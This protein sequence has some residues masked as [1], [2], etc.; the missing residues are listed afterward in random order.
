MIEKYK[1]E[2]RLWQQCFFDSEEYMDYYFENKAE[3]NK[4]LRIFKENKLVSMVHLNPYEVCWKGKVQR[5]YYIVGVCTDESHR[6]KGYMRKLLKEGFKL[7]KEEGCSFTYLM[8][9]KKEIYEPFDFHFIYTQKRVKGKLKEENLKAADLSWKKTGLKAVPYEKL[10][11]G[12]QEKVKEF[13][14]ERLKASFDLYA[15]RT[16]EYLE[17]L[18]KEMRAAGGEFLVIVDEE[19]TVRGTIAYMAE[20]K[21]T[22]GDCEVV[23][24]IMAPEDS[25][26][27]LCLL[28]ERL[29]QRAPILWSLQFL[30]TSFWEEEDILELLKE[31]E[32]YEKPVIMARA[33]EEGGEG[34]IVMEELSKARVYLNEIV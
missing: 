25:Q 7:M 8:P 18:A 9:A 21:E 30:E 13:Q 11:G 4:I 3:D 20:V 15:A 12:V 2:Y 23:E 28:E 10:S 33:L 27:L 16:R 6:K 31:G 14:E 24:G 17:R 5:L 19:E 29:E 26:E 22:G 34:Q 1:E 32:S